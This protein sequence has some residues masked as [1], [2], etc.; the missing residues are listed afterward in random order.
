MADWLE[1]RGERY[2]RHPRRGYWTVKHTKEGGPFWCRTMLGD[3]G[4]ADPDP[5]AID[6]A[7][8]PFWSE[9]EQA[10]VLTTPYWV[11]LIIWRPNPK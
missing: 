3:F 5:K 6:E 2:N 8:A 9:K 4:V 11:E 7:L 10:F 1:S